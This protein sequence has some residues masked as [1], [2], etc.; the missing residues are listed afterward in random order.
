L[1][2]R[3]HS[4]SIFSLGAAWGFYRSSETLPGGLRRRTKR[5]WFFGNCNF[6]MF[7]HTEFWPTILDWE[8]RR[9]TCWHN[10]EGSQKSSVRW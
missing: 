5:F 8:C 7:I 10:S 9:K 6:Y 1:W 4:N 2:I 3:I